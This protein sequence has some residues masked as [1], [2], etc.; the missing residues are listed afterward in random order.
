MSKKGY[1]SV[2]GDPT[3][4]VKL[5]T[6]E[7]LLY[8]RVA[9]PNK[10]KTLYLCPELYPHYQKIVETERGRERIKQ[11]RTTQEETLQLLKEESLKEKYIII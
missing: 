4:Q 9:S 1:A 10:E 6:K 5:G 8:F 3:K 2:V 11:W 7:E